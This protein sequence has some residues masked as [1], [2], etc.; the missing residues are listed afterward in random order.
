MKLPLLFSSW[1]DRNREDQEGEKTTVFF[2]RFFLFS[3]AVNII[4]LR[5]VALRCVSVCVSVN[6]RVCVCVRIIYNI[7]TTYLDRLF[8]CVCVCV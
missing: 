1:L 8:L 3:F 4:P 5:C 2:F 6:V 7:I